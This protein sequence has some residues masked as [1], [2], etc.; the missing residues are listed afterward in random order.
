M[1]SFFQ[2][3]N[4]QA[5]L[6]LYLAVGCYCKKVGIL[7]DVAQQRLTEWVVRITLPCLVFASFH[8][9]FRLE[10]L[11][12]GAGAVAIATGMSLIALVLGKLL[13]RRVPPR[14]RCILQYGTLVSNAGFAG[15]PIIAGAYGAQG[16]FLASLFIIPTRVFMWSAGISLFTSMDTA[17]RLKKVLLN[18]ALIAVGLGL[19][20]MVLQIPLPAFVDTA[21]QNLGASTSPLAM[22]LVGAMLADLS[23]RA[24][25][26]KRVLYLAFVRQILLPFICLA[27]LRAL[28]VNSLL[29]AVSVVL[30]GMP[31][32]STTAILAGKYGADAQFASKCVFLS[33]LTSLLTVPLLTLFL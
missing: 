2:M 8:T 4:V 29:A 25:L 20:R 22:A 13:Y 11:V 27:G 23:P 24:F 7:D 12:E 5:V 31:I 6:F 16:L 21:I 17:E 30:T 32:G 19:A 33:T 1:N 9:E 14:E 28:G 15:L 18:P 26:D 3:L 10:Y